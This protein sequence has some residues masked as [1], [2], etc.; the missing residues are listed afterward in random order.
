MSTNSPDIAHSTQRSELVICPTSPMKD[1]PSRSKAKEQAGRVT[2]LCDFDCFFVSA[3]LLRR[4]ELKGLPVECH[5]QGD[6]HL[7]VW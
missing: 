6:G 7:S 4:P 2:V 5:A 1:E 3:G